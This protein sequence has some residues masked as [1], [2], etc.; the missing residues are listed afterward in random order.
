ME[1]T[2]ASNLLRV[3]VHFVWATHKRLPLLTPDIE[4]KVHRYISKVCLND[5][6]QVHAIGGT[7]NHVHLLITLSATLSISQ[8]IQ[9]V[10]GGS[11]RFISSRL[12]PDEWFEWQQHYA[13]FSLR[14][15]DLP[16]TIRYTLV[17]GKFM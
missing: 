6:C 7:D 15:Q 1:G 9:H 8:F 13:A 3:H 2:R 10:K 16:V 11:S 4:R 12:K 17:S 5:G 14:P